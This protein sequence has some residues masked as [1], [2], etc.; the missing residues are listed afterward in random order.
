MIRKN[1]ILAFENLVIAA[2]YLRKTADTVIYAVYAK[3]ADTVIYAV[4]AKTADTITS[5]DR[6]KSRVKIKYAELKE[7]N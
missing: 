6:H 4:Y 1:T 3:T 5:T 7:T 2:T